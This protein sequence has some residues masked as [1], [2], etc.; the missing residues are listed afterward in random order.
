MEKI[1]QRYDEFYDFR[2]ANVNDVDAIMD[3]IR[4]EWRADHILGRNKE[5]FLWQYGNDFYGDP[6]TINMLLMTEKD[7]TIVGVN[8]FI[9]Y[10]CRKESNLCVSSAITKVK[11]SVALP[12]SGVEL[13]KRFKNI[14]RADNYYSSGANP[15]TMIPIGEK[16]FHYSVGVMQQFYMLNPDMKNFIIAKVVNKEY[17][18]YEKHSVQAFRINRFTELESKYD[19]SICYSGQGYKSKE[20]IQHR[21]FDHPVYEYMVY[22]IKVSDKNIF[23]N[24]LIG[25]EIEVNTHKIFR[26]VDFLGSIGT[27]SAIGSILHEMMEKEN[28]EYIDCMVGTIS[29][30][31]MEKAGFSLRDENDC[32]I[33]P[34]YFEPFVRENID[35]WYQKS[36]SNVVIFK[37]DGDQDRP[38]YIINC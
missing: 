10:S 17:R 15:K 25:R 8:G 36:D 29:H 27:L 30:E 9:P 14:V 23:N 26:I 3:F 5:L 22:G 38:N 18:G 4:G 19:F 28:Y 33:I 16:V 7:G 37:A 35:V 13:I 11:A 21:Y 32:N 24:V 1:N 31:I 20:Y 6:E 2:M 12:M 34:H